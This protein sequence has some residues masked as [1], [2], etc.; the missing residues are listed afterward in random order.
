MALRTLSDV[1]CPGLQLRL[2]VA[3]VQWKTRS[4]DILSHLLVHIG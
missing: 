2:N 3:F 4:S 1:Q